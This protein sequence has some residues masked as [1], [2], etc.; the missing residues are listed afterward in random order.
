M[1]QTALAFWFLCIVDNGPDSTL[2]TSLVDNDV[3]RQC[4][5]LHAP[6][7]KELPPKGY[8]VGIHAGVKTIHPNQPNPPLGLAIVLSTSPHR[9]AAAACFT[10]NAFHASPEY[11]R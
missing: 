8:L 7:P 2:P 5:L 1:L 3:H 6:I 4:Y 10:L 11:T 9:T